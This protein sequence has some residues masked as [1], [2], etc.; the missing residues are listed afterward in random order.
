MT[1][2]YFLGI[3]DRINYVQESFTESILQFF[4]ISPQSGKSMI[5]NTV[6]LSQIH[7]SNFQ[8]TI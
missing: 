5:E 4:L 3:R 7:S 8:D 6:I 2:K 1:F